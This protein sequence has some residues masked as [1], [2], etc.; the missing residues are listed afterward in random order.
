MASCPDC[1]LRRT[2]GGRGGVWGAFCSST[3][4]ARWPFWGHANFL[5]AAYNRRKGT[6]ALRWV[7]SACAG[8]G[9]LV[10]CRWLNSSRLYARL[11]F[12]SR[13]FENA[14]LTMR[15]R[16][17]AFPVQRPPS[18][19]RLPQ[20]LSHDLGKIGIKASVDEVPLDAY[21]GLYG[22]KV[23]IWPNEF[24]AEYP[25][26]EALMSCL[27]PPSQIGTSAAGC[28]FANYNSPKVNKLQEQESETVNQPKR[29]QLVKELL[30]TVAEEVPYRP[31]YTHD[32]YVQLS[33][34]Y[35]FPGFSSWTLYSR[36]WALDVKLAK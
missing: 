30:Q 2:I 33:N 13:S 19:W 14:R 27:L 23:T 7:E 8:K 29:L 36:P 34:K 11:Q 28:N 6:E 26:P 15:F 10:D 9:R 22:N 12:R 17:R 5:F 4:S 3:S 16:P 25:D 18:S 35:V 1:N 24:L 21:S 31:L 32:A 20:I